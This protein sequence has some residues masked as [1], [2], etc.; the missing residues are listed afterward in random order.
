[1]NTLGDYLAAIRQSLA[2][3]EA[4][5]NCHA[6]PEGRFQHFIS[7]LNYLARKLATRIKEANAVTADDERAPCT[8][9]GAT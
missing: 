2:I 9:D 8:T 1:M 4:N 7:E 5:A 6:K 3:I